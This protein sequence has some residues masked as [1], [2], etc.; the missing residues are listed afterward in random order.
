V[1][2][3]RSGRRPEN[4]GWCG[5]CAGVGAGSYDLKILSRME[6]GLEYGAPVALVRPDYL[7]ERES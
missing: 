3:G 6:G 5:Y 4:A 2:G 7:L 1:A